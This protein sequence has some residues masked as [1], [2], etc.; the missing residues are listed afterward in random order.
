[1]FSTWAG[2]L[3]GMDG[4]RGGVIKKGNIKER[5]KLNHF[6]SSSCFCFFFL[7]PYLPHLP[8]PLLLFTIFTTYLT[9]LS[10]QAFRATPEIRTSHHRTFVITCPL[11]LPKCHRANIWIAAVKLF[12]SLRGNYKFAHAQMTRF[13]TYLIIRY[14]YQWN[15]QRQCLCELCVLFGNVESSLSS[16]QNV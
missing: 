3:E 15:C 9:S 5:N 6:S 16:P 13:E 10:S 14:G 11:H 1:M 7:L 4:G 8:F 2:F 12:P